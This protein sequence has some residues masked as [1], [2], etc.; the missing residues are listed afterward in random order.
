MLD[1]VSRLHKIAVLMF[2]LT[3]LI[4]VFITCLLAALARHFLRATFSMVLSLCCFWLQGLVMVYGEQMVVTQPITS[5]KIYKRYKKIL[6][7]PNMMA[8]LCNI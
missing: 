7:K 3:A 1:A 6:I 4:M 2:A 5:K 8:S